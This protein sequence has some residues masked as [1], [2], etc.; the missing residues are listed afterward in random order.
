MG[1]KAISAMQ[2]LEIEV[3]KAEGKINEAIQKFIEGKLQKIE[4]A[5]GQAFMGRISL[6]ALM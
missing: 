4:Q 3:Y 6:A 1:P 5:T 2:Q